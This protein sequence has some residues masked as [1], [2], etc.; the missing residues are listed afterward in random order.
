MWFDDP[1]FGGD[2]FYE[3]ADCLIDVTTNHT[4]TKATAL[5]Q[6]DALWNLTSAIGGGKFLEGNYYKRQGWIE[7]TR[8]L[9]DR[10]YITSRQF[11]TWKNPFGAW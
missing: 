8:D 3:P 5:Q 10:G 2:L 11:K 7:F 9:L 4:M 6:F 1:H